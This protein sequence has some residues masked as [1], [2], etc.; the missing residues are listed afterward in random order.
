D[1]DTGLTSQYFERAIFQHHPD[2]DGTPYEV[3]LVRLGAQ[4]LSDGAS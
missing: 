4:E 2:N 3:L 1:P